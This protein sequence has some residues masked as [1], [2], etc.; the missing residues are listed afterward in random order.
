MNR[1]DCF[2]YVCLYDYTAFGMGFYGRML[3]EGLK[4]HMKGV[5]Q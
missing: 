1:I 5:V 3:Y 4:R 2:F